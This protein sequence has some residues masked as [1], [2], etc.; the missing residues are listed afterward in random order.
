MASGRKRRRGLQL[1]SLESR[2]L[3]AADFIQNPLDVLDANDDGVL[4]TR[5]L[6]AV[7]NAMTMNRA[8][9][10]MYLDVDGDGAMTEGDAMMLVDNLRDPAPRSLGVR[11]IDGTGNHL[12]QDWGA[13]NTPLR[14]I[15]EPAYSDGL[16]A[17][18]GED[19]PN[20]RSISN[21]MSNQQGDL[22]NARGLTSM[23]W[24]WGQFLDHDIDLTDK[25][26][27]NEPMPVD[28]PVGDA[29]FD[30]AASGD[31]TMDMDRS[32]YAVD[33]NGVRQQIN[34]I[35]AFIDG[36]NIYGSD[37]QRADALRAFQ[38]GRLITSDNDLLPFNENQLPN[39]GSDAP[40][41]FLAGDVRANEQAGLIA[42]HTLWMREHN[43][44]ADELEQE[45]P[46]WTDEDLYQTARR[47]V[48]AEL[49]A[50]TYNEFLPVLLGPDALPAYQGYD[51]SVDPSISNEFST[52]AY[53]FGHSML[54][55][56]LPRLTPQ[57]EATA[58][59]P[60][61]LRDAFFH[62]QHILEH[63]VDSLLMGLASQTAQEIDT[64]MIDDVRNFLFGPPGAGGF[65]LATLNIQRGRDHGLPDY[66][67]LRL[68]MGL[69]P[70]G[71]FHEI[72]SDNDALAAL[73]SVYS[74]ID[75]IDPWIGMLAEDHYRQASVGELSYH[76]L[77][78]QF[79]RLRDGDRFW[80]QNVFSGQ[81]LADL[82]QTRLSDI[83]ARN[84]S[85]QDI[86]DNLF[87]I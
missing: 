26:V 69:T 66:N 58:E 50:I 56:E 7:V 63:G 38:G 39:A 6:L 27:P 16:Q 64:R 62:P 28:L 12:E 70:V 71:G 52:A 30:P 80:Y 86:R 42:M 20:P 13:A 61:A 40:T 55:S 83:I 78:D 31:K 47:L 19:R 37:P 36:S 72:T 75:L 81:Q 41:M 24:Q 84:T 14:R 68:A 54:S 85:L 8:A 87:L 25:M 74:E 17:P 10:N 45:H 1:E 35:T 32:I 3:F 33:A 18:A 44:I 4:T 76:I 73:E 67:T 48:I 15:A 2:T 57:G 65:D 5:D 82:E 77:V 29:Q 51:P 60:L 9:K 43:R 49:Q 11:S 53:R 23:V 34:Q 79:T 46:H 21:A 59:G 22:Q